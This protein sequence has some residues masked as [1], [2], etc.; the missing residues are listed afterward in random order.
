MAA[1]RGEVVLGHLNWGKQSQS[2][3]PQ[4]AGSRYDGGGGTAAGG[5]REN[6]TSR[7][8]FVPPGLEFIFQCCFVK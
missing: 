6:G 5:N 3:L 7:F 1:G 4:R 2:D 8:G